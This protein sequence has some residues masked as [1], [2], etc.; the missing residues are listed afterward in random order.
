MSKEKLNLREQL[1]NFNSGKYLNPDVSTQINAGW[2]DWFCKDESLAR[3]TKSLFGKLK[4]VIN[5]PKIGSLEDK[6]VFFKNN[7]PMDGS[8]YDDFRIC[9]KKTGD[10]IFT[11]TP[12]SGH[13]SLKGAGEVW[14]RENKFE[15]PLFSGSWL[16]IK[17][18]FNN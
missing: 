2:Y 4:Q 11:I 15:G 16:E 10:V 14:G 13:R 5:S 17:N 6:Y 3:K 7:C 12:K 1:S 9:D 18:W 8:L